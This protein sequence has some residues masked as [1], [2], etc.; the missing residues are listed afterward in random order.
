VLDRP[1]AGS[2]GTPVIVFP[3]I[4]LEGRYPPTARLEP[5]DVARRLHAQLLGR[6]GARASEVL[7]PLT[8]SEA[9]AT[10][11]FVEQTIDEAAHQLP[12]HHLRLTPGWHEIPIDELLGFVA[13]EQPVVSP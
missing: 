4:D 13:A 7:S 9:G 12:A 8:D 3:A 11:H 2:D 6:A 10:E 1:L 5:I